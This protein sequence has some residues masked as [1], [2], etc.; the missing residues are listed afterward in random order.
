M[1]RKIVSWGF[2]L[3]CETRREDRVDPQRV[4]RDERVE[5]ARAVRQETDLQAAPAQLLEHRQRIVVELEVMCVAPR[6]LHLAGGGVGVADPAHP[7]D[8]PLGEED[9][10]LLVVVELGMPPSVVKAALRASS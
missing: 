2:V 10:D 5:I 9:P 1:R 7:L 4:V 6:S 8:D 3:P